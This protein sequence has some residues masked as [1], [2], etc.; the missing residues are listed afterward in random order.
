MAAAPHPVHTHAHTHNNHHAC[1]QPLAASGQADSKTFSPRPPDASHSH[2]Q[3]PGHQPR[4]QVPHDFQQPPLHQ[5]GINHADPFVQVFGTAPRLLPA[6][7]AQQQQQQQQSR[8]WQPAGQA[9]NAQP[10]KKAVQ[11]I[12]PYLAQMS[13]S[14]FT[15]PVNG[16]QGHGRSNIVGNRPQSMQTPTT[17]SSSTFLPM[18]DRHG[19]GPSGN[20]LVMRA[21]ANNRR[22]E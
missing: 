12:N 17:S 13:T 10:A 3:Q 5:N 21:D 11:P 1:L 2:Q 18:I 22:T 20:A 19:A 9:T 15:L 7:R 8:M 4:L 14:Q 6:A 16:R